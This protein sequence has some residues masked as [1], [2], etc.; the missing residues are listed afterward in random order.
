MEDLLCIDD[1][2]R[3]PGPT[4]RSGVDV[5]LREEIFPESGDMVSEPGAAGRSGALA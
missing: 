3:G 4:L 2:D 5:A 1:A